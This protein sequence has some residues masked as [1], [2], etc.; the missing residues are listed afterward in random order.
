MTENLPT[1][2]Q[3]AVT[4]RNYLDEP[5][6]RKQLEMALPKWLTVDRLL[7]IVFSTAI[8]N[9]KILECSR[10][11]ILRAVMQCAQTG[12]EPILGRAWLVPYKG[13]L[14]FQPGYQGLVDLARRSGEIKDVYSMVVYENDQFEIEYG[15]ER[16][17]K[18]CPTLTGEPGSPIGAYAVWEHKDGLKSFE[19]MSLRDVY[20][21]RDVSPAYKYAMKKGRTDTPWIEWEDEMIKKTVV[22]H[23]SKLQPASIEFMQAVE[24][25]N[26]AQTGR[27]A[28]GFF[29][30]P[31]LPGPDKTNPTLA[32]FDR[33]AGG[34]ISPLP[35][36]TLDAFLLATATANSCTVDDIKI[37][38]VEQFEGFWQSFEAWRKQKYPDTMA[39]AGKEP[40]RTAFT[41]HEDAPQ[42]QTDKKDTRIPCKYCGARCEPGM[43]MNRHHKNTCT[44]YPD[45]KA[46]APPLEGQETGVGQSPPPEED[47][48]PADIEKWRSEF[49]NVHTDLFKTH[50]WADLMILLGSQKA[51]AVWDRDCAANVL[52]DPSEVTQAIGYIHRTLQRNQ[53]TGDDQAPELTK[54]ELEINKLHDRFPNI[55]PD[56]FSSPPFIDLLTLLKSERHQVVWVQRWGRR[57]ITDEK[58]LQKA[59]DATST[60]AKRRAESLQEHEG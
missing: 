4:L 7:R 39:G 23:S 41:F 29:D 42:K 50:S 59:V 10:E 51:R 16:F 43:G 21:R 34:K 11:S 20:K 31:L 60:E 14:E 13:V 25:D 8:K 46:Y 17:L 55:D 37:Q 35:D 22:I 9:P 32:D 52:E 27:T 24:L 28:I 5:V 49:P 36:R 30:N 54:D 3:K 45:G 1:V 53:E 38:A 48:S 58:R 33:L 26:A 44:K 56:L 15:T 6:I 2:Q 12:L 40:D 19:F 47:P 18:H 57:A